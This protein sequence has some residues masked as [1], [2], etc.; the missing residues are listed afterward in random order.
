VALILALLAAALLIAVLLSRRLAQGQ[1]GIPRG[2]IIY[3]DTGRAVRSLASPVRP[4]IGK[5][6]YVVEVRRGVQVPVEY[7]S[8]AFGAQPPHADLL[9]LGAY[10]LLLEDLAGRRPP[11]GVLRYSNRTIRVAF[12]KRLRTEVLD[13]LAAL[14]QERQTPPRGR[15]SKVLCRRC[16]FAPICPDIRR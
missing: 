3:H 2:K 10:L 1:D 11:Y 6:D 9:Q 12:S 15:P 5:P 7:K 16:P 4:L 8:Y 14:Q 13:T